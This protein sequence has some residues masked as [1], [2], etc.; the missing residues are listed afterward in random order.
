MKLSVQQILITYSA[1]LSTTFAVVLLMGAKPNRHQ[2]F[3]EIQVH[4]I[5]IVEPDGTLRM[6]VSDHDRMPG[7][8]INGKE[9][10]KVDRPQAG[11]LF[12]NDEGTENGGLIFGG[13]RNARGEVVDS[14]GS[15]SFDKYGATQIVQ[16]VGVDD[17][18]NR[19]AGLAVNDQS[20]RIWVGR[21][22]DGASVVSL[23]DDKGRKRLV[24][25]VTADGA[26]SLD[27]FDAEGH[28]VRRFIPGT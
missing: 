17:K 20:R 10:P 26:A 21:K 2:V 9:S 24:M 18:D 6:V 13:H 14:G 1:V 8:I 5:D 19:F 27:F 25:Q 15:L 16:L 12:F 3:D 28:V 11:M 7:V 4:R 22:D 23:M